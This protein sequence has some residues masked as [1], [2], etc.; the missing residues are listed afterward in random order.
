MLP[1]SDPPLKPVPLPTPNPT[2]QSEPDEPPGTP[3]AT[4]PQPGDPPV[5]G[6]P[7]AGSP[8]TTATGAFVGAAVADT[9]NA[10]DQ[11]ASILSQDEQNMVQSLDPAEILHLEAMLAL[12][13][14]QGQE[15]TAQPTVE[16]EPE[17]APQVNSKGEA[18]HA[19]NDHDSLL[20]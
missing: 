2:P 14:K 12:A 18:P 3:P 16:G 19:I 9:T 5:L 20:K 13:K 11:Q 6:Q 8:A 17:K 1:S 7:A 4:L 10:Q 15:Q